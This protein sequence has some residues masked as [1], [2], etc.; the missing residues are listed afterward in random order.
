MS[1]AIAIDGM[2]IVQL[3]GEAFRELLDCTIAQEGKPYH[4]LEGAADKEILLDEPEL[5]A[6]LRLIIGVQDLGDGFR[7][8]LFLDRSVIISHI[9]GLEIERLNGL[10]GP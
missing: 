3:N 2:G 7:G 9:E 10:R 1:S 4:V 6:D 8:N 5:A